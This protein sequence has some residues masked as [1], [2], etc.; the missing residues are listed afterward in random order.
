MKKRP[1]SVSRAWDCFW[2]AITIDRDC[3]LAWTGMANMDMAMVDFYSFSSELL[4]SAK[5]Y[6]NKAIEI[7]NI[8]IETRAA[9]ARLKTI[10]DWDWENAEREFRRL[11]VRRRA[12]YEDV[13]LWYADYLMYMARYDEAEREMERALELDP[14]SPLINCSLGRVFYYSGRYKQAEEVF[15]R[16]IKMYPDFKLAYLYLGQVYVQKSLYE[17]ALTEL[18]KA[19]NLSIEWDSYLET[20]IAITHAKMGRKSKAQNSLALL[21]QKMKHAYVSPYFLAILNFVLGEHDQGFKWLDKAY[22]LHE[23]RLCYLK[24]EPVFDNI[25]SDSRFKALLKKINLE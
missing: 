7:D 25:R 12:E 17:E 11:T 8:H 3:A 6:L 16:T 10:Y 15:Q 18:Q 9:L 19:K 20:C 4:E 5:F 23:Y 1:E 2:K 24:I 22:E 21:K 13:Y 14:F